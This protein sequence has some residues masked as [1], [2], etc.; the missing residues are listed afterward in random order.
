MFTRAKSKSRRNT[1]A[2]ALT[3][4]AH[5]ATRDGMQRVASVLILMT[6]VSCS[7]QSQTGTS[8]AALAAPAADEASAHAGTPHGNHDPRHGGIVFMKGD[9]HFEVVLMRS[10]THEIYFSDAVRAE[11]PA[12]TASEVTLSFTGGE[13]AVETL[14]AEIDDTGERWVARG[15]PLK[16]KDATAR[17]SFVVGNEPYWI[18]IPYN[19][20]LE[21]ER[22][23]P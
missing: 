11:L 2:R 16:G 1:R 9:L 6:S 18:D 10:G 12:S 4:G 3:D 21:G 5:I 17:V 22:E 15:L 8:N 13:A 23:R 19:E 14:M 20:P 7:G